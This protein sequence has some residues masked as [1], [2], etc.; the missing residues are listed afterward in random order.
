[1][2]PQPCSV[3]Y[4]IASSGETSGETRDQGPRISL[5]PHQSGE[6]LSSRTARGQTAPALQVAHSLA[7]HDQTRRQ[8][9]CL[10]VPWMRVDRRAFS[11][12]LR[13]KSSRCTG[14]RVRF[15]RAEPPLVRGSKPTSKFLHALSPQLKSYAVIFSALFRAASTHETLQPSVCPHPCLLGL[16]G[17]R[18]S[19]AAALDASVGI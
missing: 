2:R 15:Y 11:T 8:R 3:T 9:H 5:S 18:P 6:L 1:M 4:W 7:T 17:Q 13:L 16:H 12:A 19:R 10:S 14:T